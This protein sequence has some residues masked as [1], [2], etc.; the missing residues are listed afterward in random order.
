MSAYDLYLR[1]VAKLN[2][3][4][5]DHTESSVNQAV[6][7]L[8]RAIAADQQFS[9]AYGRLASAYWLRVSRGWGSGDD[10]KTHGLAAAKLAVELGQDEPQAL[11]LGGY[12]I[13]YLGGR[14]KEGW[15]I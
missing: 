4:R 15:R 3:N 7:L 9:A 14:L 1:A 2:P 10:A 5:A 11:Y 13:A 12:A 8:H 6:E